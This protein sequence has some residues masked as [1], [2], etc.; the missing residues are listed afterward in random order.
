MNNGYGVFRIIFSSLFQTNLEYTNQL[1]FFR[2]VH[3]PLVHALK[4]HRKIFYV[5]FSISTSAFL[6]DFSNR[7][8]VRNRLLVLMVYGH[9]GPGELQGEEVDPMIF[10]T[11]ELVLII[12]L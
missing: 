1:Y 10:Y 3:F 12:C 6:K 8:Q 11:P 9:L 2:I 5:R 4:M 7:K